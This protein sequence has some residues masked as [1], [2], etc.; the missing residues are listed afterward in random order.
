MASWIRSRRIQL[1]S[2][3]ARRRQETSVLRPPTKVQGASAN[4]SERAD[5]IPHPELRAPN[6]HERI[7][8][9]VRKRSCGA[10]STTR[11]SRDQI[12]LLPDGKVMG[13]SKRG[14][15][16]AQSGYGG[17]R[18]NEEPRH[19][20]IAARASPEAVHLLAGLAPLTGDGSCRG[21]RGGSAC[22]GRGGADGLAAA[23]G[24]RVAWNSLVSISR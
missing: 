18:T 15:A 24:A 19:A 2:E 20:R 4:K 7:V 9:P 8:D 14:K 22:G 16:L 17:R 10:A 13:G 5:A 21:R 11:P 23:F 3:R 6:P 1:I 12:T